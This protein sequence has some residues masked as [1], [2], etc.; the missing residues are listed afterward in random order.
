MGMLAAMMVTVTSALPQI[1]V[2]VSFE[3]GG[4]H[5]NVWVDHTKDQRHQLGYC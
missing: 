2:F 5:S 4:G 3:R 1:L